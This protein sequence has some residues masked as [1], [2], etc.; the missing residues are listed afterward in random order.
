MNAQEITLAS[1]LRIHYLCAGDPD[2]PSVVLLHGY[3]LDARLWQ[4]VIPDLARH[5]FVL[6]PDLPGHGKSDKPGDAAYDLDFFI[7]SVV[8][9]MKAV[10]LELADVVGHDLGGMIALGLAARRPE[11]V[12]GLV[13][14]DTAPFPKWPLLMRLLLWMVRRPWG[15]RLFLWRPYFR[16]MLGWFGFVDRQTFS[17][18]MADE[19]RAP[20]VASRQGRAALGRVVSAPPA[21]ISPTGEDLR[22]IS[23]PTLI[24][25][26]DRDNFFPVSIARELAGTLPGSELSIV[27]QAG[28][29]F[30]LEKPD[31]V[32]ARLAGFLLRDDLDP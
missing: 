27:N 15:T 4:G 6:A 32:S 11:L 30:P 16:T 3:P 7:E 28:H 8:Q 22:N 5:F 14:L 21:A 19:F 1:G 17:P 25:W 23:A 20:W 26:A 12:R 10:G 29:F 31:K 2:R 9:I 13:I 18:E 24:L